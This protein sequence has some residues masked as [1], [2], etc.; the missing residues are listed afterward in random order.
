MFNSK[1]QNLFSGTKPA[2]VNSFTPDNVIDCKG[3]VKRCFYIILLT[4]NL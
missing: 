2:S 1:K 3:L 4:I